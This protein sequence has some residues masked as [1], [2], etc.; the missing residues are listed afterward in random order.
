MTDM[1]SGIVLNPSEGDASKGSVLCFHGMSADARE[2]QGLGEHLASLG[3]DIYIPNL[4][5]HESIDDAESI[6]Y[7]GLVRT[8][9]WLADSE[10]AYQWLEN[11]PAPRFSK[12][13]FSSK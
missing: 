4:C 7:L 3:F 11:S 1:N 10:K 5:G 8:K 12:K 13:I 6:K 2:L 9:D